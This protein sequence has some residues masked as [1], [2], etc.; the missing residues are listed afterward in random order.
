MPFDRGAHWVRMA[1]VNLITPLAIK[2]GFDVYPAAPAQRLRIGRRYARA[3]EMEDYLTALVRANR[4]IGEAS[5]GRLDIPC[6]P[7]ARPSRRRTS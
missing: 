5:R 6:E 2:A 3:G 1:D 4:A 7:V